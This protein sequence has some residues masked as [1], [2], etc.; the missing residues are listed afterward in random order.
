MISAWRIQ[1]AVGGGFL[2][3]TLRKMLLNNFAPLQKQEKNVKLALVLDSTPTKNGI[4]SCI[5]W[6]APSN[7]V[8]WLITVPGI[9]VLYGAFHVINA[10]Y[11]NP[12]VFTELR[13]S[14]NQKVLLP[15]L[16]SEQEDPKQV[17]RAYMF[18]PA[19]EVTPVAYVREHIAEGYKKG[20]N[21]QLEE[22]QKT[23]HVTYARDHPE[24]YWGAIERLWKKPA[25]KL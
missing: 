23:P 10:A 16:I 21:I 17:R 7:P 18:S 5:T 15:G 9:A 22:F 11:G 4:E 3:M 13:S 6:L 20:Y 19:D 14:L 8:L 24:R 2:Y 12:P 1:S 25:A